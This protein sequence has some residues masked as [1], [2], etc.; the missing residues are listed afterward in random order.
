MKPS[1]VRLENEELYELMEKL[2]NEKLNSECKILHN[3]RV[4]YGWICP[5]CGQVNAPWMPSCNCVK[6]KNTEHETSI[7]TTLDRLR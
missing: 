4:N 7:S 3:E 6:S 2:Q 1:F 5:K